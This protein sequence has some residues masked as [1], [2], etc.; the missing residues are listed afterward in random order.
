MTHPGV[1][2]WNSLGQIRTQTLVL[3]S[4][5]VISNRTQTFSH[6]ELILKSVKWKY[7]YCICWKEKPAFKLTHAIENQCP[8]EINSSCLN[9][10]ELWWGQMFLA[11]VNSFLLPWEKKRTE[12]TFPELPCCL[13]KRV[14]SFSIWDFNRYLSLCKHLFPLH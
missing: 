12:K 9:E 11:L 5:I 8:A 14:L 10:P 2:S 7:T 3:V 4:H 13:Y 1:G 6:T